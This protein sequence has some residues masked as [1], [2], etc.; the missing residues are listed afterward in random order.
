[1]TGRSDLNVFRSMWSFLN[2]HIWSITIRPDDQTCFGHEGLTFAEWI[3]RKGHRAGVR[4]FRIIYLGLLVGHASFLGA[5][6]SS[7]SIEN[8]KK[9]QR[10][11]MEEF[12][13]SRKNG[14][15]SGRHKSSLPSKAI[16]YHDWGCG[17]ATTAR[18]GLVP[19]RERG[20]SHRFDKPDHNKR[21]KLL[22]SLRFDR[23]I[24]LVG[25]CFH[26]TRGMRLKERDE[27]KILVA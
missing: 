20:N 18:N 23:P 15:P 21:Y 16:M 7:Q 19:G 2:Q 27:W 5:A 26:L 1:M 25:E 8:R 17:M 12:I 6:G 14:R 3:I 4:G 22:K 10:K 24:Q 9:S 11:G 13:R